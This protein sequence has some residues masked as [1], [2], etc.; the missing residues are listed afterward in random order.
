[1]DDEV[2]AIRGL[3][4]GRKWEEMEVAPAA[5][6]AINKYM[7]QDPTCDKFVEGADGRL[8]HLETKNGEVVRQ[9]YVPM[10][11]RGRLVVSKHGSAAGGH[12]AAEETLAKLRKRY[13][14]ASIRRDVEQW[15]GA[16]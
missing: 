9:L 10:V 1:M 13:Y 12:R 16:C 14:W 5:R 8:Y 3:R 7:S 4:R 6:D 15:I 11:M 2:I